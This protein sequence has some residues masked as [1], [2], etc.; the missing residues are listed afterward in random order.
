MVKDSFV[1]RTPRLTLRN[2]DV[3]DAGDMFEMNHDPD[4]I[5]YTGDDPF[6]SVEAAKKFIV[7]YD[8]Y[9]RT[10]CGRWTVL[11]EGKYAGWCGLNFN[12]DIKETDL[13]FR[14]LKKYW[15]KGIATEAARACVEYGFS[16]LGL[17]KIIGRAMEE[18]VGSI[19]VLQKVGMKFE[20]EFEAHGGT[21]VQYAIQ[22]T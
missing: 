16:E 10:G 3:M 5:R 20:K 12:H 6:E 14:F 4:V 13:G 19:H 7:G 8:A 11:L 17:N 9:K 18:N 21:C 1:I 15:N 22:K 2:F